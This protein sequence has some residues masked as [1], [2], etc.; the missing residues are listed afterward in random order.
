M[1]R[2]VSPL[3]ALV[4]LFLI[5]NSLVMVVKAPVKAG[6][7]SI[8]TDKTDYFI[9]ERVQANFVVTWTGGAEPPLSMIFEWFTPTNV[10]IFNDTIDMISYEIGNDKLLGAYSNW[11][12]NMNGTGF[13]VKGTHNGS[14]E[15]DEF[16]FNVW[17][18]EEAVYV[19]TLTLSLNS[20]FY[21]NNTVAKATTSIGYLGNGS[22]LGNVSFEWRYPNSTLA[23]TE[24]VTSPDGGL[25]GTS[26][27]ISFWAV[28]FIGTN[29]RVQATYNGVQPLSDLAIFDVIP[30]RV[31]IWKNQSISGFETWAEVDSPF[32]VC[33]NIT[34]QPGAILTIEA[35][36]IVRFCPDAGLTVQ[37]TLVMDGGVN[38]KINLTSYLYPSSPGDWKGVTFEE[39]SIDVVSIL[40]QVIIEYS[41][42]GLVLNEAS[43]T[44]VNVSVANSSVSGIEVHLSEVLFSGLW[45]IDS[46]RGIYA[47]DSELDLM[48]S[49]ILRCNDGVV[50]EDSNGTL[51][52]NWIHHNTDKGIWL[53]RSNPS[54][55]RNTILWNT[56]EGIRIDNSQDVHLF[57]NTISQSNLAFYGYQSTGL[58]LQE[59]FI[60]NAVDTGLVFWTSD[61]VLIENSTIASSPTS[62]RVVAASEVTTLNST[63]NDSAVFVSGGSRLYVDN[64]LHVKLADTSGSR[65]E[66][67]SVTLTVDGVPIVIGSTG[68]DGWMKWH[69]VTYETFFGTLGDPTRP[70]VSLE[71]TLDNYNITNS[72][73]QV[74]MAVS[75]TEDFEGQQTAAPPDGDGALELI[76]LILGI[77]GGIIAAVAAILI[78]LAIRRKK[79]AGEEEEVLE[80]DLEDGKAYILTQD[81]QERGF[82][83]FVSELEEGASGVCFTRTYPKSLREKY[84][85]GETKVL[86][87][88]RDLDKGGLM[89]TNLGLITNEMD[90][91]L[92]KNK[93]GRR[94]VLLDGLEYLIA[95]N[96]FGKVLKLLNHL[97]DTIGVSNGTLLIPF[98]MKSVEEK[99]AAMLRADLEV[100]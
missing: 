17:H 16:Y 60:S 18:Y 76:F 98:D 9:G 35:G 81:G 6:S 73:R 27:V 34:V 57:G 62:I 10:S 96:G 13:R 78:L 12:S 61:A 43:P 14:G 20:N 32:G 55:G 68:Q 7:G 25:N 69:I 23:F 36:S 100:V 91:F 38:S 33:D 53:V 11:T 5:L 30:E 21:E 54:L 44:V 48:D 49:E 75:H 93:D 45:V 80:V 3:L 71:V 22:K 82:D 79:K 88:S 77:V 19:E 72:P 31:N 99:D 56:N 1:A 46:G 65:L 83:I 29:F 15:S 4:F 52:S 26:D 59:N 37:G 8:S 64:Y 41:Q 51:E 95:Q 90:K 89:P 87:L 28:D 2:S 92:N 47:V 63:F 74:N 39:G 50:M 42:Q 85:L 24:N 66:G 94:I 97:K 58:T 40:N 84:D 86:W 67:A 70:Q